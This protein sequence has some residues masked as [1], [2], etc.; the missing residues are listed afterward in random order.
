M[1][2]NTIKVWIYSCSQLAFLVAFLS[3]VWTAGAQ[4]SVSVVE[5]PVNVE[6]ELFDP[7]SY[8]MEGAEGDA[9]I[10]ADSEDMPKGI[11]VM[12]I[13]QAEGGPPH[14]V[15]RVAGLPDPFFVT[16]NDVVRVEQENI[17]H[18][19]KGQVTGKPDSSDPVYL[20][21]HTISRNSVEIS[22]QKRP[23]EIHVFQ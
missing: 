17:P 23:Q 9:F 14:A 5:D 15:L 3:M 11:R 16:E 18:R 6:D 20:R 19:M 12:A 8:H 22:P 13:M 10:P 2:K 7:F 21:I 4:E 1:S